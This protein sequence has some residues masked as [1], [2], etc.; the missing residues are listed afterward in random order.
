MRWK[1]VSVFASAIL[2]VMLTSLP[3]Q[4]QGG[5]EEQNSPLAYICG[6]ADGNG[7]VAIGDLIRLTNYLFGGVPPSPVAAGDA[8]GCGT[9]NI[10]DVS[11]L[12]SYLYGPGPAPCAGT[13]PC[14]FPA[15]GNLVSFCQ[16]ARKPVVDGDSV[17][18]PIYLSNDTV[19]TALSLGFSYNSDDIEVSSVSFA[20]SVLPI[21]G[22]ASFELLP[23]ENKVF[24]VWWSMLPGIPAQSC[25]LLATLWVQVP[26]GTPNQVVV[27]D[28]AFV[29]P[30]GEFI[31][32]RAGGGSI[33]PAF[34]NAETGADLII[35]N[36][37]VCGDID[38]D[39]AISISDLVSLTSYMFSSG[40]AP[41][42]LARADVDNCGDVNIS[43]LAYLMGNLYAGVPA[44]CEGT[45]TCCFTAG[46]NNVSVDMSTLVPVVDGDSVAVSVYLT[47][48]VQ[49][50]GFS[51][52]FH[53]N[54]NDIEASS[55]S[56]AGSIIPAGAQKGSKFVPADNK[57]LILDV[58]P[59]A[60]SYIPIQA[61]GL[62]AK[63]WFQVPLGTP[64]QVAKLDSAFVAPAGEFIL[65]PPG[66]GSISPGFQDCSHTA[67]IVIGRPY[68]CGDANGDGTVN[69]SDVVS[70]IGLVFGCWP[71]HPPLVSGDVNC[72][73]NVNVSDATYL[74]NYIF[75]PN[76]P[77]P[78]CDTDNNG[79][80]E[81]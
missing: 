79:T 15:G 5:T 66:G 57:V 4:L 78:P 58:G 11:Y 61:G 69:I 32:S 34:R 55:V 39:N 8:D 49:L 65:S 40:S 52:G 64:A 60:G 41:S 16:T 43:D 77:P 27:F 20:G 29:A 54:S 45:S 3:A 21:S 81:C 10:S 6:D 67:E 63:I 1:S 46:A 80:P 31:F 44:P 17:G 70:V 48:N 47:N 25:G 36:P 50:A 72:D 26:S 38:G 18:I 35:G 22:N 14:Y 42:P 59:T 71:I 7:I 37:F 76:S 62:L 74:I 75:N 53:Y 12:I 30:G 19:I 9:V 33:K 23:S 68:V 24:I 2:A 28:S 51:L 73:G 56:F 13:T